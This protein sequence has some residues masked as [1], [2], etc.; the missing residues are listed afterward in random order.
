METINKKCTKCKVN[1]PLHHFKKK[2]NETLTKL[3]SRCLEVN[4]RSKKKNKCD[5][6]IQK[7]LCKI[8]KSLAKCS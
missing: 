1:L 8:C 4:I 3:C 7:Y 2:R 5:H 6:N